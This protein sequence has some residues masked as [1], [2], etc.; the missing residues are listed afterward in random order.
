MPAST[1][2]DNKL[3]AATL[4]GNTYT[5]P[6]TVYAALYSTAPTKSTSGTELSGSGYSRQSVAFTIDTGNSIATNTANVV[7]GNATAD[8][9]AAVG[10]SITD[11]STSGNIL[12][13][14]TLSPAIT[15]LNGNNATFGVGNIAITMN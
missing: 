9:S 7:F 12:Y 5:S 14:S 1:S 6:A 2:L 11:A 13:F 3:L 4:T 10:W 15:V 8:W